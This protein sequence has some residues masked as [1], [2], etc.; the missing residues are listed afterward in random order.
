MQLG[1]IGLGRMATS[2]LRRLPLAGQARVMHDLQPS[3]V[4]GLARGGCLFLG[5]RDQQAQSGPDG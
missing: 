4:V 3:A 1:V 2:M 5:Q